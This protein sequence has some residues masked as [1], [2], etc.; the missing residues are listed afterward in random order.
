M[1]FTRAELKA[2]VY[3]AM[4]MYSADLQTCTNFK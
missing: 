3:N 2:L 1:L 4:A